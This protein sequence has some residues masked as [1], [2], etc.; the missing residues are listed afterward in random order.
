VLKNAY[1]CGRR[2]LSDSGRQEFIRRSSVLKGIGVILGTS[3]LLCVWVQLIARERGHYQ[4]TDDGFVLLAPRGNSPFVLSTGTRPLL[5]I[6]AEE[7]EELQRYFQPRLSPTPTGELQASHSL[8][9]HVLRV[10]GRNGRFAD[11]QLPDTTAVIRTFLDS[12]FGEVVY[13]ESPL[14]LSRCGIRFMS[15]SVVGRLNGSAR[16]AHDHQTLAALVE[17]GI[18]LSEPIRLDGSDHTLR[19]VLTDAVANFYLE[20]Q[21]LPWTAVALVGYLSPQRAWT[22]KFGQTFTFDNVVTEL[23]E[24][25]F[26]STSCGG[27]HVLHALI[28][29]YQADLHFRLLDE[30][31]RQRLTASIQSTI[32]QIVRNQN[33]DGSWSMGWYGPASGASILVDDTDT[34]FLI[35]GHLGELLLSVPMSK[36]IDG[37]LTKAGGWILPELRSRVRTSLREQVCPLTHAFCFVRGIAKNTGVQVKAGAHHGF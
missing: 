15:Q 26:L 3:A 31:T 33:A 22:N 5:P 21:E 16:E 19:E 6:S 36:E 23:L 7:I 25:G 24:G 14:C 2:L 27:V 10:A 13:G 34:R 17:L 28:V 1:A 9:I 35:T 29:L 32:A 37:V 8:S 20:K 12:D 11:A 18:P 30:S 4:S